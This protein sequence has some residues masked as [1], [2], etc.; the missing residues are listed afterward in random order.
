MGLC[1]PTGG[2]EVL[3]GLAGRVGLDGALSRMGVIP[4]GEV[5][6]ERDTTI[7]DTGT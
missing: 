3:I 4:L 7:G 2:I 5:V 6:G 1:T